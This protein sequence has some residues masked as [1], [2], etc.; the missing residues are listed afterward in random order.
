MVDNRDRAARAVGTLL[1]YGGLVTNGD[2][3]P[4]ADDLEAYMGDLLADMLHLGDVREGFD[5]AAAWR[6]AQL[7]HEAERDG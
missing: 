1:F 7:H 6:M 3:N 4:D 5:P 2:A